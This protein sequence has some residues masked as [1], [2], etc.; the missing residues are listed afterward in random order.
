MRRCDQIW[1]I[2]AGVCR[3]LVGSAFSQLARVVVGN[4]DLIHDSS[5]RFDVGLVH[6]NSKDLVA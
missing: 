2:S 3:P 1:Q 5:K 6:D 4:V